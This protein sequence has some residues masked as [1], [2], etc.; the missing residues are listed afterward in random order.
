M[1]KT[2]Y[3]HSIHCAFPEDDFFTPLDDHDM[4]PPRKARAVTSGALKPTHRQQVKIEDDIPIPPP[5]KKR[6]GRPNT[7][8]WRTINVG[9]S[10]KRWPQTPKKSFGSMASSYGRM[11]DRK[12]VVRTLEDGSTRVW[13]I[14]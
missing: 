1:P 9:Q 8:P 14:K 5:S 7:Y 13:R 2:D 4:K 6:R 11:L 10:F 3:D 12:F